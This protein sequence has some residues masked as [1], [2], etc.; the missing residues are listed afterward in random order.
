MSDAPPSNFTPAPL[1]SSK[2]TWLI[3]SSAAGAVGTVALATPFVESFSPSERAKAAGVE[4]VA[5][6]RSGYRYHGR[7]KAL[8]DAAREGGLQF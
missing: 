4:K 1:D 2:R 5:F 7:V 8:A 6:D 3:A